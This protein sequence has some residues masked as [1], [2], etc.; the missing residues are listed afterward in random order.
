MAAGRAVMAELLPGHLREASRP[1][2][3]C[4]EGFPQEETTEGH[5]RVERAVE[6]GRLAVGRRRAEQEDQG[7]GRSSHPLER[8]GWRLY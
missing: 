1:G 2:S 5:G 6:G 3:R 4:Q 8:C 7:A